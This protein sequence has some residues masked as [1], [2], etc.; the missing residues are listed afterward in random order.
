M[1]VNVLE[2]V[3]RAVAN[4]N[5]QEVRSTAER[6]LAVRLVARSEEEY[7]AMEDFLSP[8]GH[9]IRKRREQFGALFRDAGG[10]GPAEFDLELFAEGLPAPAEA[11]VFSTRA[12]SLTVGEILGRRE[13]LGL[14][15]ARY[16]TPFR[17]P[18]SSRIITAVAKENALFALA[19][20]L[21]NI[22][23]GLVQLPWALAEVGSDTAFL[24][25]N[26]IRMI[27][28]LA[29]AH[30]R[31]VGYREQR[32]EIASVIAGAFGWRAL[33]RELAG[34]IP[35]GGGLVPKAA[36]AFAGTY[37]VGRSTQRFYEIGAAYTR[38][39]RRQ[40]FESALGRGRQVAQS[41]LKSRRAESSRA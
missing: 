14:A 39:E 6:R 29:G 11:F 17:R 40:A 38:Q 19:T 12:P 31:A 27:F 25:V 4:L 35:F 36:V 3:R 22:A 8:P 33:A 7:R 34:K 37:T 5:P 10:D 20:A 21:P 26:Q 32:A 2:Q 13:E 9:S 28:L 23:P 41:L 1:A 16:F 24:T 15:L 30:D 18:V